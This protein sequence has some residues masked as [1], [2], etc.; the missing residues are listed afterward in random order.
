M[1]SVN[2]CPWQQGQMAPIKQQLRR[3]IERHSAQTACRATVIWRRPLDK[4][5]SCL[6]RHLRVAFDSLQPSAHFP[7]QD[8]GRSTRTKDYSVLAPHK[9]ACLVGYAQMDA[10]FVLLNVKRVAKGFYV[11]R[12]CP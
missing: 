5:R 4:F 12:D 6:C 10:A 8:G 2:V 11:T 7:I 1:N 9:Y 3:K